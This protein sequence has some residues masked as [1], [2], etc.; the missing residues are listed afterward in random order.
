M[1]KEI[2]VWKSTETVTIRDSGIEGTY[3]IIWHRTD[4]ADEEFEVTPGDDEAV[5][6]AIAN[7][8]KDRLGP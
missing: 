3:R 4:A 8:L 7:D 5:E 1:R 6:E 2:L